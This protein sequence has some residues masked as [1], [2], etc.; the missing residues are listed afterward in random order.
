MRWTSFIFGTLGGVNI[1]IAAPLDFPERE[2]IRVSPDWERVFVFA[3]DSEETV[4][5]PGVLELF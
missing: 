1:V 4:R 5:A 3:A 2:Q